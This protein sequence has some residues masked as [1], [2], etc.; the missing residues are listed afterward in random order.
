MKIGKCELSI[1][2]FIGLVIMCLIEWAF[3]AMII[4]GDRSFIN[5]FIVIITAIGGLLLTKYNVHKV[6]RDAKGESDE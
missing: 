1:D 6:K 5:Y 3:F 2:T 4:M